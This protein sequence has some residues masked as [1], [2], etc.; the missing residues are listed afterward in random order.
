MENYIIA[1]C[2]D[3]GKTR[4]V[5]ED[6]MVTFDSP[7]GRVVAVCDGMGGQN[8]GDV[9][10]QLAVAVIQDILSDNTFATPEEA[11]TSSVIAANQAIL[12]KASMN[13]DMLGMGATCV[14]LIVKD[15]KVY[16]GSIGDS[17]IYYIANGMIR[18][19]TKD[20]SYVQT[21]VDA[22]QI[23]LAE[24]EHHQ[25]KNQI[26]NALGVEGMTP[27]VIGQMPITP[28]PNS[29]FLLCSD[30]LSGMIN[31]NTILNT[32]SRYDL[33]LNERA[34]ML[35]EQANEAGG[36]DNITVQL[37]E[38]PAEDMAMSPMGSPS[39]SSAIAQPKKKSHA[40][41][42]SLIT[43]LLVIV[44]AGGAYWYFHEDE[45]PQPK[46]TVTTKVK[47]KAKAK[48]AEA[49]SKETM[50]EKVVVETPENNTNTKKTTTQKTKDNPISKGAYTIRGEQNSKAKAVKK[51]TKQETSSTEENAV[52]IKY[53]KGKE[54]LEQPNP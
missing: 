39:V 32:V 14:M 26:T 35:V 53:I 43:A 18:Q 33:S 40:V 4:R 36:L 47:Q 5:N 24:A 37:V 38:F 46:A 10:S 30:G 44:V 34:R 45:K 48:K 22:G 27:P 54:L 2:T 3:T 16:Y 52:K 49:S 13:E 11:I 7:N 6:S 51:I 12:R 17:R 29:T 20:Q 1:N 28:E 50:V 41:L 21:L 23:T 31:N 15:G 8:A 9:A 42:Y 19:I 25:D